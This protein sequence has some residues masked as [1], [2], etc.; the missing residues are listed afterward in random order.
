[1]I[2]DIKVIQAISSISQRA[3]RQRDINKIISSYVEVGILPQLLNN[4]NQILYGRRGTGKTHI[5]KYL[6]NEYRDNINKTV[7]Y[8][9]CRILGSSPQF[10]DTRLSLSHRCSSLFIDVLNEIY[11]S[12]LNHIAYE[13][14]ENSEL[15]LNSLDDFSKASIGEIQK[16]KKIIR[17]D[18]KK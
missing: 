9:D 12:L 8:I 16:S 11:E 10:S 13:P 15:A 17:K 7:C 14:N 3:E 18:S 1:M 6:Q 2:K 4:N 5:L